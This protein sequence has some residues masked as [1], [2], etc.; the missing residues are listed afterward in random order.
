MLDRLSGLHESEP[1]VDK[2]TD[3]HA[4]ETVVVYIVVIISGARGGG[5]TVLT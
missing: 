1:G 5:V 4:F 3:Y 2:H